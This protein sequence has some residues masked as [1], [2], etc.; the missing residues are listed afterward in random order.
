MKFKHAN[1]RQ[2][3][4]AAA[5]LAATSAVPRAALPG[6]YTGGDASEDAPDLTAS[7]RVMSYNIHHGEGLDETLDLD[8][9]SSVIASQMPDMVSLQEVDNQTP[10]SLGV[11]QLEAIAVASGMPHFL[12]G[13][14]IDY[15]GGE[16][17]VAILSR[18]PF[19]L[20]GNEPLPVS[21][22]SEPRTALWVE[23][24]VPDIG[25]LLF[26]ATHLATNRDGRDRIG[27]AA[28]LVELFSNTLLTPAGTAM[29]QN[30]VLAGDFNADTGSETLTMLGA[31]FS[32][33]F[34][35]GSVPTYPADT[36]AR[37]YDRVMVEKNSTALPMQSWVLDDAIA[38]D[39]RPVIVDLEFPKL[40]WY[41]VFEGL[42]I[43]TPESDPAY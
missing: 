17:G 39:H 23:V 34:V 8:R 42:D 7:L 15:A 40:P 13:Q 38:S 19:K 5:A 29:P 28:R 35:G 20:W 11:D 31:G 16:Y 21:A 6:W 37:T 12:F 1:R 3:L 32:D 27:Q 18:F 36:P 30:I 9:I 22:E 33:A 41:E 26:V 24:V 14:A 4:R 10:R 2:L 25:A 43:E